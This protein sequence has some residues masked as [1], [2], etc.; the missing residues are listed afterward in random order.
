MRTGQVLIRLRRKWQMSKKTQLSAEEIR[1]RHLEGFKMRVDY[2]YS[3]YLVAVNK[4]LDAEAEKDARY[5]AWS[6]AL[7]EWAKAVA[8]EKRNDN[9]EA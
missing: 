6:D 1:A 5:L 7:D 8:E 4:S 2:E 9:A 3:Q